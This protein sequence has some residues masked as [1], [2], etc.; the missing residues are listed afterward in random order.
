MFRNCELRFLYDLA[1]CHTG[2]G[3]AA[4]NRQDIGGTMKR[5]LVLLIALVVACST[6]PPNKSAS[7]EGTVVDNAGQP[8][9]GVTVTLGNQTVVTDAK[10]HYVFTN[11][12]PGKQVVI[13]QLPGFIDGR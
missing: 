5:A 13:A 11:V 4:L 3:P 1:A 10:G 2:N 7:R 12:P 6:T 9:P 8:I